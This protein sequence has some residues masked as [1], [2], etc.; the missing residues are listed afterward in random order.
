MKR[1]FEVGHES[2]H[3]F[4]VRGAIMPMSLST[5]THLLQARLKLARGVLQPTL[6]GLTLDELRALLPGIIAAAAAEQSLENNMTLS[7]RLSRLSA[8]GTPKLSESRAHR[9][10]RCFPRA[11]NGRFDARVPGALASDGL[12]HGRRCQS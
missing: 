3:L 8:L 11:G 9:Q 5:G 10:D 7:T 6:T 12:L 1:V 2:A 4:E